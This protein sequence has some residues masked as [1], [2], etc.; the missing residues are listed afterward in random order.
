M[1]KT[2][3]ILLILVIGMV[4][5]FAAVVDA[6]ATETVEGSTSFTGSAEIKFSTTV[7]PTAYFALSLPTVKAA[8]LDFTSVDNFKNSDGL[9]AEIIYSAATS[10]EI[11]LTDFSEEVELAK[12]W[13]INNSKNQV[14]LT[15]TAGDGFIGT[16]GTKI[17]LS[18]SLDD[19]IITAASGLE[20]GT[21]EDD[22]L[23]TAVAT[24]TTEVFTAVAQDYSAT[25]TIT[26]T[27]LS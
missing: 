12:I 3:A 24:D 13:G 6:L 4:G 8:D 1:K 23:I 27:S 21:L 16:D 14:N 11:P 7:T 5:V 15:I 10:N 26:V 2:I 20:L 18:L 9:S 17:G 25:I 19:T 22:N